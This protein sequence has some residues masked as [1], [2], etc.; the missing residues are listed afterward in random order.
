MLNKP[1]NSITL[2]FFI[3]LDAT[4]PDRSAECTFPGFLSGWE[5]SLNS[6]AG[7][8]PQADE[9]LPDH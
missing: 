4:I 3:G 8:K 9:N 2:S 6:F 1:L 7:E 5:I